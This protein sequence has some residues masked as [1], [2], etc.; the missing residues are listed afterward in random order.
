MVICPCMAKAMDDLSIDH[1]KAAPEC[2]RDKCGVEG[3]GYPCK[4]CGLSKLGIETVDI[5]P[6]PVVVLPIAK[7]CLAANYAAEAINSANL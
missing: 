2:P 6:T 5:L 7:L 1:E 3:C 4:T